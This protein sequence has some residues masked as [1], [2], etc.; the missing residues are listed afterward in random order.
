ME[1]NVYHTMSYLSDQPF[2]AASIIR[3]TDRNREIAAMVSSNGLEALDVEKE[4]IDRLKVLIDSVP[5]GTL[6][7]TDSLFSLSLPA[8]DMGYR[9][10][11]KIY[12]LTSNLTYSAAQEF[13]QFMKLSDRAVTAGE[14]CGGYYS[15]SSGNGDFYP[16]PFC[17]QWM[18]L[19]IP[20]GVIKAFYGEN[21][22]Y[23]YMEVDIPLEVSFEDWLYGKDRSLD[24][25][26]KAIA[27][28]QHR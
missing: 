8:K 28:G 22:I 26:V 17:S 14:P 13:A 19:V 2:E 21:G 4:K 27:D 23:D 16:P 11:G 20:R 15:I 6:L 25:L 9:Y 10:S 1:K 5:S 24:S 7:P 12:L 18:P 3:V